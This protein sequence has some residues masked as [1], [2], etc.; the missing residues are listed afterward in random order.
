MCSA[1]HQDQLSQQNP[2]SLLLNCGLQ[3][4]KREMSILLTDDWY[5]FD[6]RMGQC[7]LSTIQAST[8]EHAPDGQLPHG[9]LARQLCD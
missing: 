8:P 7:R 9:L 1:C 6:I 2:N 4:N 3:L 5:V